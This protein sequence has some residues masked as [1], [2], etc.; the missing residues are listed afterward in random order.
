MARVKVLCFIPLL[1]VLSGCFYIGQETYFDQVRRTSAEWS[2][3]DILTVMTSPVAHNLFDRD[4]PNIKV[5]AMPYYPSVILATERRAQQA[6]HWTEEHFRSETEQLLMDDLGMYYDWSARRFVDA[7]GNYL[8]APVQFDSLL[9]YIKIKNNA[10][11]CTPPMMICGGG[12]IC[13]AGPVDY[14]CYLPDI[15]QFEENVTLTNGEGDTV[16]PR[17]VWGR[18]H[19]ILT[20]PEDLLA[21]FPLRLHNGHHLLEQGEAMHLIVDGFE[22]KINL[23]FPLEYLRADLVGESFLVNAPSH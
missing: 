10:F 22:T 12:T 15:T 6:N 17:I 18:R 13:L 4:C 2:S 1:A 8:H 20:V 19:S 7:R 23:S 21:M 5:M 9:F 16:R 11:P 3:R 14:S